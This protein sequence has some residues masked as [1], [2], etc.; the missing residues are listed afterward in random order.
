VLLPRW[1]ANAIVTLVAV[2]WAVTTT[3]PYWRDGS[4]VPHPAIHGVFMV[5]VGSALAVRRGRDGPTMLDAMTRVAAALRPP[6]DP[7]PTPALPPG[8][9]EVPP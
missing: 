4:P 9:G 6:V 8:E 3:A 2:V 1:L 5:V 7:P